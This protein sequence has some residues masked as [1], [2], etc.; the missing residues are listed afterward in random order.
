M[1]KTT[2]DTARGIKELW[3]RYCR[4]AG[5]LAQDD[6]YRGALDAVR[7]S[8]NDTFPGYRITSVERPS[9]V[10]ASGMP[11]AL[12]RDMGERMRVR[13]EI[14][15]ANRWAVVPPDPSTMPWPPGW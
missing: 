14:L 10:T 5:Y 4:R 11:P 2:E 15:A 12:E 9:D 6:E 13:G 1:V 8:W 3:K 7:R